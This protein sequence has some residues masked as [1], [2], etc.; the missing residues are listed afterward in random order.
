MPI[1]KIASF[2]FQ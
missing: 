2:A 1:R